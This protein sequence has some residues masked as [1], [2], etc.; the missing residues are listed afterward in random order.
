MV[1]LGGGVRFL[2]SEVPLYSDSD[3]LGED[4]FPHDA[5]VGSYLRLIDFCITQL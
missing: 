1:A 3:L 4:V 2:M 5:L